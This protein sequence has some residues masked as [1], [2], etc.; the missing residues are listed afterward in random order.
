MNGKRPDLLH[1]RIS[2]RKFAQAA[3]LAAAGAAML[4]R[5]GM[6]QTET[7]SPAVAPA[8]EIPALTPEEEA[9]AD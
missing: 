6:A 9:E 8:P 7:K 2:R 4:P 5:N 3:T 1:A